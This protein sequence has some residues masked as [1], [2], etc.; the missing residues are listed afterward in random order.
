[1]LCTLDN[2]NLLCNVFPFSLS[3]IKNNQAAKVAFMAFSTA[4]AKA[5]RAQ[6]AASKVDKEEEVDNGMSPCRRS[7]SDSTRS[8]IVEVHNEEEGGASPKTKTSC[9]N[10][11]GQKVERAKIDKPAFTVPRR[12]TY[13][14]L[15]PSA[16]DVVITTE[17]VPPPGA[18]PNHTS[19]TS[20]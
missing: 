3:Q 1:M 13:T 4:P 12:L 6:A 5:A 20:L 19:S 17:L 8:T 14:S 2:H 18:D 9:D 10:G 7:H 15:W 11:S 16:K